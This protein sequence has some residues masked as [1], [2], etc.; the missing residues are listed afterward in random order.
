MSIKGKFH[1]YV[2]DVFGNY[3]LQKLL[4]KGNELVRTQMVQLMKDHYSDFIFQTYSCRVVQKVIEIYRDNDEV[5]NTI[6]SVIRNNVV[7]IIQD[8]NGNHVI[9]KCFEC[10]DPRKVEFM[11][12]EISS[13]VKFS[14]KDRLK[15]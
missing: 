13:Q 10:F 14:L 5:A 4:D 12:E 3:I 15:L 8:N 1:I 2:K 7:D 11:C 9:Q 6:L